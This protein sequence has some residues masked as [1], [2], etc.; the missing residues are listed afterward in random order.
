M[1]SS[2]NLFQ[3]CFLF[4]LVL[5]YSSNAQSLVSVVEV[6][7]SIK[8]NNYDLKTAQ[9]NIRTAEI[10]SS[11]LSQ[12]YKPTLSA[13]AG[14]G[15][16]LNGI[17]QVFNFNFPDIDIQNIQAINGNIGI[18]SSYLLYDAGQRKLRNEQNLTSLDAAHLQEDNIYQSLSFTATQLYYNIVQAVFTIH[19]LEESFAISKYRYDRVNT[20]YQY[21]NQNKVDV[22][23]AEVDV[24]R[25]SLNL[26]SV[27][28]D[29][30]NLK[31]Q[32]N[33]L[34][35]REDTNYQVDTSFELVYKNAQL[36]DLQST[37][38]QSNKELK[39]LEKNIDLVQY[40]L[41][42]ADKT[43]TPQVFAN[44]GYSVS[45]QNNSTKSQID[46][47]RSN[48]LNLGLSANWTILD[49]GQRK[50][51]NQLA[52]VDQQNTLI[53]LDTRKNELNTQINSLWNSYQNNLLNIRIEEQNIATNRVNFE[54]VKTL[55]ESGQQ[56]S[57]EFRQ[58]Q[59]NLINAQAQY[60]AARTTA[61]LLEVELDFLLGK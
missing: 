46:I 36:S 27:E 17:K 6:L 29:I 57:V 19:L 33:Q 18:S 44:G 61:K 56:G 22:L 12:G 59:L 25:D 10:L 38:L 11:K 16:N 42:L 15:Y 53:A 2:K 14:V 8:E 1:K 52:I 5:N 51:Q 7:S 3:L 50:L 4:V 48:G 24:A 39:V 34:T 35:L 47:N 43:N 60:Y 32:L 21:G 23:N 54:L 26:T 9:Q 40:D 41:E 28:N 30:K 13:T 31:W 37:M 45:F 20:L 58:A 49:D 55:Y